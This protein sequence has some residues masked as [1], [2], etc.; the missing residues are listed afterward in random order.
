M[1][2]S[3]WHL[4]FWWRVLS[5]TSCK[6]FL[7]GI[8][9]HC[10]FVLIALVTLLLWRMCL[11]DSMFVC[12]LYFT[13]NLYFPITF[14]HL[15]NKTL[16]ILLLQLILSLF[17]TLEGRR[18]RRAIIC[19]KLMKGLV[20]KSH[21]CLKYGTFISV[22]LN[23]SCVW[24]FLPHCFLLLFKISYECQFACSIFDLLWTSLLQ[25]YSL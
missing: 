22:N 15:W 17:P 12:I 8:S 5:C 10:C 25:F 13:F 19:S 21:F 24:L 1:Q 9:D 16:K 7:S 18:W 3:L 23:W 6:P 14:Y 11:H 2:N 20:Q 4:C